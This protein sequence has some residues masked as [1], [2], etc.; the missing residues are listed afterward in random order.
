MGSVFGEKLE[1]AIGVARG[2]GDIYYRSIA[3]SRIA[4]A[5]AGVDRSVAIRVAGEAFANAKGIE[6]NH[7]RALALLEAASALSRV[8][9]SGEALQVVKT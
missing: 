1:E 8:G 5:I 9:R 3:L 2:I 4:S 6:G 7:L